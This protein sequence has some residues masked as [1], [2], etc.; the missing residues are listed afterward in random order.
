M[1]IV[2][3]DC[4]M[5]QVSLSDFKNNNPRIFLM[6]WKKY[7]RKFY[8][9]FNK[10]HFLSIYSTTVS[11][12]ISFGSYKGF[13]IYSSIGFVTEAKSICGHPI[14][15]KTSEEAARKSKFPPTTLS[16]KPVK[17]YGILIYYYVP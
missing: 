9:L 15:G 6:F 10:Y 13:M 2:L 11:H 3:T 1:G 16:G 7:I 17:V 5:L 12:S 8:T 4:D 14:L